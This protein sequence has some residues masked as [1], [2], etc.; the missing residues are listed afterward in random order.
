MPL[1][2]MGDHEAIIVLS[3]LGWASVL[4]I[5]VVGGVLFFRRTDGLILQIAELERRLKE[6][7]TEAEVSRQLAVTLE[8]EVQQL[9]RLMSYMMEGIKIISRQLAEAGLVPEWVPP[10]EVERYLDGLSKDYSPDRFYTL[11]VKIDQLFSQDELNIMM[12]SLGIDY[13]NIGGVNKASRALNFVMTMQ[14]T[15]RMDQLL[16]ALQEHRPTGDW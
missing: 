16:A 3:M 6:G 4:V 12:A 8:N 15:G 1:S 2:I 5:A 9:T 11:A 14:R 7:R 10:K 13:E